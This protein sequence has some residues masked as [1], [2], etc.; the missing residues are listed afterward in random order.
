METTDYPEPGGDQ[1]HL[2][3]DILLDQLSFD[4]ER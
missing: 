3:A 2:T 1:L 4:I